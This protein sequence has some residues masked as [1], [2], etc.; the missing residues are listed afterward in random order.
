MVVKVWVGGHTSACSNVPSAISEGR[1]GTGMNRN[2][3]TRYT[4]A[5]STPIASGLHHGN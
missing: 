3:A 5:Q 4:E 1:E 2:S